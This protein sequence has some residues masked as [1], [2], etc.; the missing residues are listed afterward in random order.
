MHANVALP[1]VTNL[2]TG[3]I[4][5]VT[6]TATIHYLRRVQ[7][8]D[9]TVIIDVGITYTHTR[10]RIHGARGRIF[11][12]ESPPGSKISA[13]LYSLGPLLTLTAIILLIVIRDWWGL[14]L[15]LALMSARAFNVW[16]IR[17]RTE[18]EP[19]PSSAPNE[20]Q[21][22]W[23]LIDDEH[24]ICLRGLRHDLEA[25][26][27]GEWMRAKTNVE[28]YMEASAKL[29]VYLVAVFSGNQTQSGDIILMVLL[30]LSAGLLALSNS[31]ATSFNMN[32]R[33]AVV[34]PQG[35]DPKGR[36][37]GRRRRIRIIMRVRL[38][39]LRSRRRRRCWRQRI[40]FRARSIM[41]RSHGMYVI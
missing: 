28:G 35:E 16:I 36:V 15:V 34:T 2:H 5:R 19:P 30:G 24:R 32:G 21:C 13:F 26:T 8:A 40:L 39:V 14:G 41:S 9:E 23:V 6:N 37:R 31:F 3:T 4:S 1:Q 27:T 10:Y 17:A 33:T 18:D 22:W 29:I 7:R 11:Q 12:F 25:I 20:H 38:V